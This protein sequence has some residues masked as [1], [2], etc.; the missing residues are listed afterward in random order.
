M[1]TTAPPALKHTPFYKF[2]V[3]HGAKMVDYTGWEMP[4]HY[5]SIIDEHRQVR[6]SGGLFDVSHMGRIKFAG[7]DA[8]RFLDRICTRQIHGMTDGQAR[9]SLV[10]NEHGGCHDDVLI[11]RF[12]DSEYLM[13]CN[14]ANRAKILEHIAATR[15]DL[16]FQLKD[17]TEDTAMIAIQG[18]KVIEL[19]SSVSK[20]VPALK[21]YRFVQ[22]SLLFVKF[23]I[24]RTGY[25]GED[26]VEVI[27][28]GNVAAKAVEMLM[29]Q[30]K[31]DDAAIKPVGLGARDSLRLEA[32]M[33]LY[34][35]ELTEE[36]DPISAGLNFAVTLDK[37]ETDP[38]VEKFIGQVALKRIAADGPKRKLV[39]LVLEGRRS[40]RQDM[41]VSRG[42][43]EIGFVT[44]GC[45][46]PTLDKPIAMA[47]LDAEYTK[48]GEAVQISLGSATAEAKVTTL[49][50]YKP[51]KS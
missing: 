46:S 43:K 34:G 5:G 51:N 37:G 12:D 49:P 17:Q 22:K 14:A 21:R 45:L 9:Y 29:K 8:C 28:P 10:C 25:T 41:K 39:G 47:Y 32:G 13:V 40:A 18:P 35:H 23:T 36:I 42:G 7:R 20:E 50:F 16:T 31:G 15:G 2:H 4:L 27:F 30:M 44:S 26:G 19:I 6:T 38:A 33:P 11:Y 48:P 24:S 3:E 1:T